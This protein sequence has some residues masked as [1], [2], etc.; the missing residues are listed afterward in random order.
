[1]PVF[2]KTTSGSSAGSIVAVETIYTWR[3]DAVGESV[4]ED[5]QWHPLTIDGP[6]I[7]PG[8]FFLD[9]G[10]ISARVLCDYTCASSGSDA[11]FGISLMA[12]TPATPNGGGVQGQIGG[13]AG[14]PSTFNALVFDIDV[15]MGYPSAPNG[16]VLSGA[17][18]IVAQLNTGF[19]SAGFVA[20]AFGMTIGTPPSDITL[21][22]EA[23]SQ[24]TAAPHEFR[25]RGI[26]AI[27][28]PGLL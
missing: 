8:Q 15:I 9:G 14:H 24:S 22:F 12:S 28:I 2:R 18:K 19:Q 3:G 10:R 1:M 6:I 20:N 4:A 27:K 25:I 11:V 5:G 21:R 23:K 7:V 16:I 13:L 26:D 17:E